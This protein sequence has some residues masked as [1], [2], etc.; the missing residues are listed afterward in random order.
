MAFLSQ[1]LTRSLKWLWWNF[2]KFMMTRGAFRFFKLA[3]ENFLLKYFIILCYQTWKYI[4]LRFFFYH[5]NTWISCHPNNRGK[6]AHANTHT[7]VNDVYALCRKRPTRPTVHR[8]FNGAL[9]APRALAPLWKIIDLLRATLLILPRH[10]TRPISSPR[11]TI[12]L[13]RGQPDH[14]RPPFTPRHRPPVHQYLSLRCR[15]IDAP[16]SPSKEI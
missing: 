9:I 13:P 15:G 2:S 14:S 3:C 11:Q 6:G 4:I 16:L 5:R 12:R 10:P 8:L 7:L 1:I